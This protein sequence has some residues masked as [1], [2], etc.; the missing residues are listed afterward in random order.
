MYLFRGP[1]DEVL[2]VGTSRNL[3]QRVRSYF[4]AAETRGR[5]KHMVTLAERVDHVECAHALEAQVREQRLIAAHQPPYN[6]RSRAPGKV[7]WVVLTDEAFPRL[8]IV[9][10]APERTAACLGPFGT[11][12]GAQTAVEALQDAVPVR[13]CTMRIRRHHPDGTPCALAE[14]GRC[15]APCAGAEDVDELSRARRP[16]RRARRR[17]IGRAARGAARAADW[18]CPGRAG[19]TRRRCCGIGSPRSRRRSTGGS[20]SARSRPSSELVA[21]RPDGAGGWE[22]AVIRYGRFAAGGR[23]RRGV[24]PMPV[25]DLLVASAETVLP[26]RGPL[27]GASAE[28]SSTLLRW[29]ERP[30]TRLVRGLADRG[31][32]RSARP[33]GGVPFMRAADLARGPDAVHGARSSI[34]AMVTA[35]V[36]ID[37]EADRITEAAQR[38]RRSAR[39]RPGLLAA[40]ATS[41]WSRSPTLADHEAIAELVPGHISKVPGVLRTV[42]HIAFRELLPAATP[43]TPSP[44]ACRPDATGDAAS[45]SGGAPVGC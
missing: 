32:A 29:V 18:S 17:P 22:L 6:R 14:L 24:D 19:S 11:R 34:W 4:S 26:G 8:S 15:G 9:K 30:G 38:D 20:G 39:R 7:L 12:L 33:A 41:I 45:G 31:A 10:R 37:V 2:Y 3:R 21:A 35:I 1:N 16:D 43:T 23:A 27:P 44:S 5:I 42:T 13:R 28:E 36:L 25:V 40:P